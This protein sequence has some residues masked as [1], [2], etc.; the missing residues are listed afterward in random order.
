MSWAYN[1]FGYNKAKKDFGPDTV[2]MI[3]MAH[4]EMKNP[5]YI[6]DAIE[7][8]SFEDPRV[9]SDKK[10]LAKK[11]FGQ[12]NNDYAQ[13]TNIENIKGYFFKNNSEPSMRI[14]QD[15]DFLE[16]IKKNK[17]N[18]LNGK[19]ISMHFPRYEDNKKSNL[20]F[21]LGHVDIRN[22]YL[23]KE[24]N[25][26][27]KVYDTYEFNKENKTLLNQA[28]RNQMLK[29]TLIPYFTIHD[30]IIPK[31]KVNELWK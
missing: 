15:P 12:F 21:A 9:A 14:S 19:D 20:H 3:D 7:L 18:I 11:L 22:G 25:L 17:E 1:P 30:I 5:D 27:I 26:R 29:G 8:K 4:K 2:G 24:G 28:G 23:D 10:Y 6:K 16:T 31:D 13:V